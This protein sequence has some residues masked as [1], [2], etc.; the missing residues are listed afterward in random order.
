MTSI[1]SSGPSEAA[2]DA[3]EAL[4]LGPSGTV[5]MPSPRIVLEA[6][7]NPALGL[8]RSVCLRDVVAYLQRFEGGFYARDV[9]AT[10]APA[11]P[12]ETR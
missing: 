9:E 5:V 12:G 10:F 11:L 1:G 2:V 8:D 7:H 6:A 4:H 3:A